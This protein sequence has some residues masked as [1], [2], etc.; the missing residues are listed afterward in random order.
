MDEWLKERKGYW[1][2]VQDVTQLDKEAIL[3]GIM[4]YGTW[5]DFLY[6]KKQWGLPIIKELFYYMTVE[7]KRVNLRKEPI[8]L[9]TNYLTKYAD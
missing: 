3:E 5:N 8:A 2:W 7:K 6:L 9:Y 1:W 4:N